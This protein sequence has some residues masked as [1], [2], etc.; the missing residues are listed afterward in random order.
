M[1]HGGIHEREALPPTDK[2]K[3]GKSADIMSSLEAR[4]QRV[5]HAMADNQDKVEDIDQHIDGLEGGHEELHGEI[6]GVM[7]RNPAYAD[8]GCVMAGGW[9][10]KAYLSFNLCIFI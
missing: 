9:P 1:L 5:G 10:T 8:R 6:Q 4:L 3:K 7:S 2:G